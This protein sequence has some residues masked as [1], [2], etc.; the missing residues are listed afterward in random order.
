[1]DFLVETRMDEF[2]CLKECLPLADNLNKF[3]CI[4][5]KINDFEDFEFSADSN[6]R[7]TLQKFGHIGWKEMR[8]LIVGIKCYL[9]DPD[10]N[11]EAYIDI[12][13]SDRLKTKTF[14]LESLTVKNEVWYTFKAPLLEAYHTKS[15]ISLSQNI[16]AFT[17]AILNTPEYVRQKHFTNYFPAGYTSY[18]LPYDVH[19]L[20]LVYEDEKGN[21]ANP[22]PEAASASLFQV[23]RSL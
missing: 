5:T 16:S 2:A 9:T 6:L 23:M 14:I 1:M 20:I 3:L 13:H 7:K 4:K 12:L 18:D 17:V 8:P 11:T 19:N 10:I 21:E 15:W 22:Y